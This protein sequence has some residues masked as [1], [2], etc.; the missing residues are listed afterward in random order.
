[1]RYSDFARRPL[2]ISH[3]HR[4]IFFAQ[5]RTGGH[6]IRAALQPHL[7]PEDWQQQALT[8]QLRL[9]VPKLAAIG[10]GHIALR[11]VQACLP[12]RLWRDYFKFTV[13]RNPYD[14][15]VSVCAFLQRDNP[16]FP[17]N[18]MFFLRD[19]I[20]RKSVRR[21]TLM[22]PQVELLQDASGRLGMDHI[23]RYETLDESFS[24]ACRLAGLPELELPRV[25]ASR[26]PAWRACYDAPLLEA[27]RAFYRRDFELLGYPNRLRAKR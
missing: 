22:R 13:V 8:A 27:V 18:E 20:Q 11:Q 5:P 14:R 23:G 16:L 3:R 9:P 4:F 6:S 24:Q 15:F 17:G 25:N 1:M 12:E 2:I 19:A 7:G 21:R 26:H 10:H